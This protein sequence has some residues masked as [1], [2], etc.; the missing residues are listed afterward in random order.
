VKAK[1]RNGRLR[2]GSVANAQA[3][4]TSEVFSWLPP[5]CPNLMALIGFSNS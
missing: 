4:H 1:L 5:K 3:T 2:L